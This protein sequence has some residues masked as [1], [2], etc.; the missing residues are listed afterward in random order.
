[1]AAERK[2]SCEI[3]KQESLHLLVVEKA[4]QVALFE[5]LALIF[6]NA[7]NSDVLPLVFFNQS[8]KLSFR[9]LAGSLE[10]YVHRNVRKHLENLFKS[11]NFLVICFH[12]QFLP[13]EVYLHFIQKRRQVFIF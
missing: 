7:H 3:G 10:F 9:F 8:K 6:A 11:G 12:Q 2:N 4:Y 5:F 1:M 13:R